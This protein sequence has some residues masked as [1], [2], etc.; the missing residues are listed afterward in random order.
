MLYPGANV[1][2]K[3]KNG[4]TALDIAN[5]YGKKDVIASFSKTKNKNKKR[6]RL[7]ERSDAENWLETSNNIVI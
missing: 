7:A 2:A 1:N 3:N 6:N 4:D 5:R